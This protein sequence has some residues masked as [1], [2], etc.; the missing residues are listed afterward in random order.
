M[1]NRSKTLKLFLLLLF[2]YMGMAS[3]AP[4]SSQG[5]QESGQRS[6]SKKAISEED[7][8]VDKLINSLNPADNSQC[9][10]YSFSFHWFYIRVITYE[11][12]GWHS[13]DVAQYEKLTPNS[14]ITQMRTLPNKPYYIMLPGVHFGTMDMLK[15]GLAANYINVGTIKFFPIAVSEYNLFDLIKN[16]L[17]FNG[18]S[19]EYGRAYSSIKTREN[20]YAR[21][22]PGNRIMYLKSHDNRYFVMTS[23]TSSLVPKLNRDNLIELGKFMNLPDGWTFNSKVLT[24]VLEVR[25][26]QGDG[27]KTKRLLDEYNNVYIEVSSEQIME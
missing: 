12:T 2:F 5:A 3:S 19:M 26:R 13:C 20:L 23:Y 16:R 4:N 1:K 21:W 10:L 18:G 8:G 14:V 7:V 9:L 11:D 15:S 27:F 24:K 17:L 25:S 22:N 6:F